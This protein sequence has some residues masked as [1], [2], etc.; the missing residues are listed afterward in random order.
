MGIHTQKNPKKNPYPTKKLPQRPPAFDNRYTLDR[1]NAKIKTHT[2][3]RATNQN[4]REHRECRRIE[5]TIVQ[6][7]INVKKAKN[8]TENDGKLAK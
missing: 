1:S 3:N 6:R 7:R 2:K 4:P 5:A 8:A